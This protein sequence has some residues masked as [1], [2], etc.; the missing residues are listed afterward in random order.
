MKKPRLLEKINFEC[1]IWGVHGDFKDLGLQGTYT[2][3]SFPLTVTRITSKE[4]GQPEN[5][6]FRRTRISCSS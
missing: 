1:Y 5:N 2:K 4:N 6:D 3:Y